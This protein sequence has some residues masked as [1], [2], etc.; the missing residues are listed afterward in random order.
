[1]SRRPPNREVREVGYQ[2]LTLDNG[3]VSRKI[4]FDPKSHSIYTTQLQLAG[5]KFNHVGLRSDERDQPIA[6]VESRDHPTSGAGSD[7]FSFEINDKLYT[8]HSLW[9]VKSIDPAT[10]SLQGAGAAVTLTS[11]AAGLAGIELKIDY[12]LYPNSPVVRKR[13]TV[14]NTS[15]N[16]FKLESVDVER[17]WVAY[18]VSSHQS[19]YIYSNYARRM[20]IGP[21]IGNHYDSVVLFHDNVTYNGMALGNEAPGF[22][23]RTTCYLDG[24]HISIGLTHKDQKMPFRKWLKPGDVFEGPWAFVCPYHN[25]PQ[26]QRV[27]SGPVAEYIRHYMGLHLSEIKYRPSFIYDTYVPFGDHL[28]DKMALELGKSAA[29]CGANQFLLDAGWHRNEFSP[30]K[31]QAWSQSCGDWLTDMRKFPRGMP[32]FFKDITAMGLNSSMWMSIADVGESSRVFRDHP[33]W[34]VRDKDG[35]AANLHIIRDKMYTAC[36]TTGWHD[37]IKTAMI[38]YIKECDLK[39]LMIDIAFVNGAYRFDDVTGC[40]ATDHPH[41]DREE[42]YWMM[43]QS[44]WKLVDELHEAVPGLFVDFSFEALGTAQMIDL[45]ILKHADGNWFLNCD[46]AP[47]AGT[48]HVRNVAW[49][50]TTFVPPECLS[51]GDLK[52]DY[53]DT[54]LLMSSMSGTFPVMLGDPRK[55]PAAQRARYKQWADW[56]A[57]A[58]KKHDYLTYRQDL[59]GFGEPVEGAWDGFQR[60]NTDTQSG[61]IVGVFRQGAHES[62]RTACIERLKP[63]ATYE[64]RRAPEGTLVTKL[65]GKELEEK[66]FEVE[67]TKQYDGV[68]FEIDVVN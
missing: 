13:L 68:D 55:L 11:T 40:S 1:M 42:S 43:Y 39:Y 21:F 26:P 41:K 18:P 5:D 2:S 62:H 47:P 12:L 45:D 17:L 53:P 15:A 20:S 16:E 36:M 3:V 28:S 32:P 65:T 31:G 8:G 56:L 34:L 58:Q 51:I 29:E 35:K 19:N 7:E 33:E 14:K 49:W 64:V 54:D 48:L 60:I 67:L 30:V 27:M 57:A 66:G 59:P 52:M 6:T 37:Y 61:G 38:K 44:A 22:L 25:Q 46:D 9:E 24:G 4:V 10:D 23:K 50:T 63:S